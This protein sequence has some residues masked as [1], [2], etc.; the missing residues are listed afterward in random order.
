MIFIR[1]SS[2]GIYRVVYFCLVNDVFKGLVCMYYEKLCWLFVKGSL[3]GG[4]G[5]FDKM[6]FMFIIELVCNFF[7]Y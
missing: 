1:Y 7:V 2:F 5:L 4:G 3:V 6:I